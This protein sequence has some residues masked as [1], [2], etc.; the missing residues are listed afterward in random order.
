MQSIN[1]FINYR[2]YDRTSRGLLGKRGGGVEEGVTFFR[3]GRGL[4]VYLKQTKM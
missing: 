3:D 1:L 2:F 4:N